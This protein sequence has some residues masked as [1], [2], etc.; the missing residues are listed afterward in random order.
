MNKLINIYLI[1]FCVSTISIH[2]AYSQSR[3]SQYSSYKLV[4]HANLL[5]PAL[6]PVK[7]FTLDLPVIPNVYAS[8]GNTLSFNDAFTK[9]DDG[10]YH[11]DNEKFLR[12]LNKNNYIRANV[13]IQLLFM[14]LR[15]G[16][17]YF[18]FN[19]NQKT[20]ARILYPTEFLQ[21]PIEGPGT[22]GEIDF[23][24]LWV[25]AS[26]YTEFGFGYTRKINE[27]LTVGG[28]LKHLRGVG[29]ARTNIKGTLSLGIDSVYIQHPSIEGNTMDFESGMA[30][31][32]SNPV[33][34][35]LNNNTGIGI[36]IGGLYKLNDKISFSASLIDFGKMTWRNN[37][38][39]YSVPE[40]SYSF[41]GVDI[42]TLIGGTGTTTLEDD[43]NNVVNN[44]NVT[45]TKDAKIHQPLSTKFYG[46]V[47]AS[48]KDGHQASL[49]LFSE[50]YNGKMEKALS[51]GYNLT[52]KEF[53]S[54]GLNYNYK[55]G[56]FNHLGASFALRA[57]FF[58]FYL[59]S[60]NI[61]L[62]LASNEVDIHIGFNM[63]FGRSADK[64][65]KKK[66]KKSDKSDT[67]EDI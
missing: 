1:I 38:M 25:N 37:T 33:K 36:D 26:N 58:Q 63:V 60:D 49:I 56:T 31:F 23:K 15:V 34:A 10:L 35:F 40:M 67:E 14:G 5:N 59:L 19:I 28:R 4:S 9:K 52:L 48:P 43:L 46:A 42:G 47:H 11:F 57:G 51:L 12:K 41:K 8:F 7:K 66:Q 21:W 50:M 17:Q 53:M 24:N 29:F 39:S 32:E 20:Q 3:F 6:T 61:N 45:E 44:Y 62:S 55:N 30:L 13:D 18:S 27:N 2:S 16:D 64:L 65:E 22:Y 54:L